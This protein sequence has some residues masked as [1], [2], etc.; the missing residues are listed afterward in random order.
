MRYPVFQEFLRAD[1]EAFPFV[2]YYCIALSFDVYLGRVHLCAN[3]RNAFLEQMS[4]KAGSVMPCKNSAHLD[5]VGV[6]EECPH[7]CCNFAVFLA[8]NVQAL[9]IQ[10]VKILIYTFLFNYEYFRSGF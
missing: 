7:V 9:V 1:P 2:E 6:L 5:S 10:V 8:E 3:L 4:A